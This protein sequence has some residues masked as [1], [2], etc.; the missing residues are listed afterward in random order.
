MTNPR[1]LRVDALAVGVGIATGMAFVGN[2]RAA[3]RLIWSA[4]GNP[5]NLA[6]RLQALTRAHWT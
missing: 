3:D 1:G 2:L 4:I 6:A 5:M